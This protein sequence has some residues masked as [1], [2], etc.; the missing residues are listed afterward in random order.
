MSGGPGTPEFSVVIAC[1]H[2]EASI[3]EFHRRL[4]TAWQSLDRTYELI[5][6]NDGSTDATFEKLE[7]IFAADSH[8]AAVVDLMRNSGQAAAITAGCALARGTNFVFLDSDLQL[9][10]GDLPRLVGEFDRGFDLV[11]GYRQSRQDAPWRRGLSRLGNVVMRRVARTSMRDIGCIFKIMDGHIVR[12]FEAGPFKP[13]RLPA[14]LA[15]TDRCSEI[16]VAHQ[17]RPHGRSGWTLQRLFTFGVE[18]LV[19]MSQ[20]PFQLLSLGLLFLGIVFVLRVLISLLVTFRVLPE[21]TT[22]LLLNAVVLSF[23]IEAAVLAA[24]GEYVIRSHLLLQGQPA[25]IVR[26]QRTR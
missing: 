10:P 12:A 24:I 2:E 1:Y 7:A 25:Y 5:F 19:S 15:M 6:V 26:T 16:P 18:N 3:A 9:D 13:L 22:G 23:L 21:V 11:S 14:L 4:S 20:R 8:V 17:T